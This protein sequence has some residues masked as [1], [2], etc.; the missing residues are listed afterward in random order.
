MSKVDAQRALRDARYARFAAA[1]KSE[2]APAKKS[3]AKAPAAKAAPKGPSAAPAAEPVPELFAPAPAEG[4]AASAAVSGLAVSDQ[5]AGDQPAPAAE[6]DAGPKA[7]PEAGLDAD[8][9]PEPGE[10]LCGHRSMNGRSCTRSKG[11]PQK[12][13]RYN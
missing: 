2:A 12:N 9:E 3:P 6:P 11:H 4:E 10:E 5:V 13:H 7:G 8:L 1:K